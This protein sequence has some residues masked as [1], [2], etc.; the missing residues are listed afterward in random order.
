MLCVL[1]RVANVCLN[2]WSNLDTTK[3]QNVQCVRAK[4]AGKHT[5]IQIVQADAIFAAKARTMNK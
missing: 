1:V 5:Y 2:S 4:N 3:T